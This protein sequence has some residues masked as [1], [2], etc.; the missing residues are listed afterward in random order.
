MTMAGRTTVVYKRAGGCEIA[1]DLYRPSGATRLPVL[2]WIHGGA[3]IM[4]S[5]AGVPDHL[6]AVCRERDVAIVSIDYRLAPQVTLPEIIEDLRAAFRW[7]RDDGP[8]V[9]GLDP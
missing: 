4:G 1:L 9:A 8:S 2:V 6:F 3:L 5:R 7:L